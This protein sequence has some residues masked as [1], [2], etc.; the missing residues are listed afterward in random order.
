MS[1]VTVGDYESSNKE[2]RRWANGR[3]QNT[4]G[5]FELLENNPNVKLYLIKLPNFYQIFLFQHIQGQ[6]I[7][8]L[9]F[10][11][12]TR[13]SNRTRAIN[14]HIGYSYPLWMHSGQ[15]RPGL[16]L[17]TIQN[18]T[19]I[20]LPMKFVDGVGLGLE[21]GISNIGCN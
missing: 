10:P 16:V 19:T 11:P 6:T 14:N 8:C 15:T 18:I 12:S 20:L 9:S 2:I 4:E 3:P 13:Q 7:F 21:H 5:T 1:T 17:K